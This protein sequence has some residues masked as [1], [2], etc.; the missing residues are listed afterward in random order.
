MR[1][2]QW[3]ENDFADSCDFELIGL[4][5]HL[6]PQRLCWE[7]NRSM[8]WKLE[9]SHLLDIS[10]KGGKSS[11]A[12]YQ[13]NETGD[14][15]PYAFHVVENKLPEGIIARF[16]GASALDYLIHLGE[17]CEQANGLLSSLRSVKGVNY[18]QILDPLHSGAIEHLALI[19]LAPLAE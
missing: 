16:Q 3:L 2:M 6:P 10:Q 12:V 11:H 7:L 15:G 18:V 17:G 9:F 19:D 5:C 4:S 13:F 8:G 14:A 1:E